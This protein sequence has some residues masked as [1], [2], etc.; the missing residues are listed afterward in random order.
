VNLRAPND[1][2][3]PDPPSESP[4]SNG[5]HVAPA[6]AII[7]TALSTILQ[8]MTGLFVSRLS[9]EEREGR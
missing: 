1:D 7:P 3:D 4:L 6:D 5:L 2:P 9:E 8:K